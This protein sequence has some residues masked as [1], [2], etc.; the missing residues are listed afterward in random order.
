VND[1]L[2]Y[3]KSIKHTENVLFT[4]TVL[5]EYY[6]NIENQEKILEVLNL[7]DTYIEQYDNYNFNQKN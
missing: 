5:L 7:L 4:L 2:S 6:Q 1:T 3:F